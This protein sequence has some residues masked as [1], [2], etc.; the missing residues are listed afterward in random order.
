MGLTLKIIGFLLVAIGAILSFGAKTF[1]EKYKVD[2]KVKIEI[3]EDMDEEDIQKY[4]VQKAILLFKICGMVVT[5]PGIVIIL[6][7][8]K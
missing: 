4:K 7:V 5:I 2:S 3:E 6:A 1:V 8:F